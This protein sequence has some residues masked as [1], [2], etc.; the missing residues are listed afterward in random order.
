[1]KTG[2]INNI[3]RNKFACAKQRIKP[4]IDGIRAEHKNTGRYVKD[5]AYE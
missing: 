1:M 5:I 3:S 4:R 2:R